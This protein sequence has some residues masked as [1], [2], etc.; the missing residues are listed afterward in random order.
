[1]GSSQPWQHRCW[2]QNLRNGLGRGKGKVRSNI[3]TVPRLLAVPHNS[4]CARP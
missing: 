4:P 1:M 2:L 3:G